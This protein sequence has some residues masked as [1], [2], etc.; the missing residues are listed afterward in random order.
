MIGPEMI[1]N[2]TRTGVTE[3]P[4]FQALRYTSLDRSSGA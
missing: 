2:G 3:N 1:G 4:V